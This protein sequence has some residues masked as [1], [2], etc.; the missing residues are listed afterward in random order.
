MR[1]TIQGDIRPGTLSLA[2]LGS[3]P[4]GFKRKI[5]AAQIDAFNQGLP[6]YEIER[7]LMALVGW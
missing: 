1:G 7:R 4:V 3:G 5:R 2:A 6:A